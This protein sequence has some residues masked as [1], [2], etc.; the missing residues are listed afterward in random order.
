VDA[1]ALVGAKNISNPN[2]DVRALA[3]E[4]C[5]ENFQGGHLGTGSGTASFDVQLLNDGKV[6]VDGRVNAPAILAKAVGMADVPVSA[7]GVAQMRNVEIMLVL[8]RSGSMDGQPIADLKVAAKSFLDF[9]VSTQD[10][11]KMGLISFA[12]AANPELVQIQSAK[13]A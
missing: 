5:T 1:A 6:R 11:D 7:A 10:K 3:S 13:P 12:T 8:D 2:V 9:F 4:F